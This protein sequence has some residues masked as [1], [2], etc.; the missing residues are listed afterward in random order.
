MNKALPFHPQTSGIGSKHDSGEW[1][2]LKRIEYQ[3]EE[4][5]KI[6]VIPPVYDLICKKAG[7]FSHAEP[8]L[9]LESIILINATLGESQ[10]KN[11]EMKSLAVNAAISAYCR[12]KAIPLQDAARKIDI[13]A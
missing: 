9:P 7:E 5:S 3:P 6:A 4:N 12:I 2:V 13:V 8:M 1:G 10:T 11:E